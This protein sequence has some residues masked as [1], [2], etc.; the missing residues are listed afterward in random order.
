M[1][2]DAAFRTAFAAAPHD[3]DLR[4]AYADWL[5]EFDRRDLATALRLDVRLAGVRP[6][7]DAYPALKAERDR[8]G[9]AAGPFGC[10]WLADAA[11]L[12]ADV[13]DDPASRWRAARAFVG[14]WCGESG[15]LGVRPDSA[16]ELHDGGPADA[17]SVVL[18]HRLGACHRTDLF[19][20][21]LPSLMAGLHSRFRAHGRL[22]GLEVFEGPGVAVVVKRPDPVGRVWVFGNTA[23]TLAG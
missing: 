16:V 4:L 9:P 11:P 19:P 10:G 17:L 7:D 2:T 23:P 12:V 18:D 20:D 13:P 15:L 5:D 8:H 6:W 21:D 1:R 3:P 14:R 22:A